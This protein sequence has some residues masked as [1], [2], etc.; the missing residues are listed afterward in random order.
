MATGKAVKR[1]DEKYFTGTSTRDKSNINRIRRDRI[2]NEYVEM[3]NRG[4]VL[5]TDMIDEYRK[6]RAQK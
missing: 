3:M 1:I 2:N 5:S 6:N 4:K